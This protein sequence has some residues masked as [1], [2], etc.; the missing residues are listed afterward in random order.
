[1]TRALLGRYRRSGR[2]LPPSGRSTQRQVRQ[3]L[4][5]LRRR[6]LLRHLGHSMQ[7]RWLR[8]QQ[9][10][11]RR[12]R[13]WRRRRRPWQLPPRQLQPFR[14]KMTISLT[15]WARP[16]RR[17]RQWSS[18]HSLHWRQLSLNPPH[19]RRQRRRRGASRRQRARRKGS[20][21]ACRSARRRPLPRPRP[22]QPGRRRPL[23]RQGSHSRRPRSQRTS[24]QQ[25][26]GTM[27][28]QRGRRRRRPL[29]RKAQAPAA[30]LIRWG[31]RRQ[32]ATEP[33][34]RRRPS[35]S[36]SS[37]PRQ[38][39]CLQ[40]AMDRPARSLPARSQRQ[41]GMAARFSTLSVRR[42]S[43]TAPQRPHKGLSQR[44]PLSMQRKAARPFQH[45]AGL[46]ASQLSVAAPSQ[47][48][49]RQ[50]RRLC[51]QSALPL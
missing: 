25:C 43:P 8:Q 7:Q 2:P 19:Q 26:R 28:T 35:N 22:M 13:H 40:R 51:P 42:P 49:T 6:K 50:R 4:R 16:P 38:A 39:L 11:Q 1:M 33:L 3:P 20:L 12:R 18:M 30:S 32:P 44:A 17:H 31:R 46:K 24:R 15:L 41:A 45:L 47:R 34:A 23:L 14:R 37:L 29:M 36:P 21:T 48:S 27:V 9:P 10:C 5:W